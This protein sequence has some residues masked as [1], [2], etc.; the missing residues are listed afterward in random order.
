MDE[1]L[2]VKPYS[3]PYLATFPPSSDATD[4]SLSGGAREGQMAELA[5]A[6]TGVTVRR[7][8]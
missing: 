6:I 4:L 5:W 2:A 3:I 8:Q 1:L 7:G